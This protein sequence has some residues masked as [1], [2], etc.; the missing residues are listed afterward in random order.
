MKGPRKRK[1][2]ESRL[3]YTSGISRP[4]SNALQSLRPTLS[5][6]SLKINYIGNQSILIWKF[7]RFDLELGFH[8]NLP[9]WISLFFFEERK[10]KEKALVEMNDRNF[11]KYIFQRCLDFP[12]FSGK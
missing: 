3:N 7:F 2:C 9:E 1:L 8:Y 5:R 6:I 11:N 4:L 10:E 12:F